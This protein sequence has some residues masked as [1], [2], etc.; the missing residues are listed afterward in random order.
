MLNQTS[1]LLKEKS[2]INIKAL[3][4]STITIL[5]KKNINKLY[6][7]DPKF[8]EIEIKLI[9][10]SL[11]KVSAKHVS[12]ITETPETRYLNLIKNKPELI[13]SVPLYIIA[14]YLKVTP[15]TLSRIRKRLFKTNKN[16]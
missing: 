4:D 10:I 11:L 14:S 15:E 1:Y 3:A 8:K 9:E 12:F 13:K 7:Q 2:K 6:K 5:S 16:S